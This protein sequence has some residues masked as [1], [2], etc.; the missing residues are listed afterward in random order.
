MTMTFK[1]HQLKVI[2]DHR[3]F[4]LKADQLGVETRPETERR[5]AGWT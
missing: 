2:E 5:Q 1:L 3:G 4:P